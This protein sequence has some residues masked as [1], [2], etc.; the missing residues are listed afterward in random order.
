MTIPPEHDTDR[1]PPAA[2]ASVATREASRG[3]DV[4]CEPSDLQA[5]T[6]MHGWIRDLFPICR[7]LTGPG[8]RQTLNY[9]GDL[10]PGLQVSSIPSGTKVFDWTV[11][12][13]WTLRAARLVGPDGRVVAD[14]AAHTLHVMGYSTPVDEDF[15]L[16]QLQPHLY[17]LPAQP[18]AIPYVTSYYRRDWGFCIPHRVRQ[19]LPAGT[20]RAMIDSTLADGVL[21]W[22]ELVIRG[23]VDDEVLLSTYICHPSMANNELSG[24]VLA[25]ALAR[26]L[27]SRD[28]RRLTHRIVFVPETI[29][30][31][32][33]L[34]RH[35]DHLRARTVAGF[36]LTCVGDERAVSYLESP[37]ADTLADRTARH[38]L[39][40]AA[41]GYRTYRFL[42]RGSDERQYCSPGVRLP[43]CSVM[44]SKHG[45]FPEYHTSLDDLAFVTPKGLAGSFALYRRMLESLES[46]GTFDCPVPC[47]PQLGRRGLYP[48]TSWKD[49]AALPRLQS[50]IL[51]YSDGG[52]DLLE[53]AEIVGAD[54]R[55]C[56]VIVDRLVAHGLLREVARHGED[57]RGNR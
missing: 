39:K 10:L 4:V 17:S 56:R 47:E 33:Y 24:P 15:T 31:I 46:N 27:L 40:H 23:D 53:I 18:D 16:E 36:V 57:P 12:P 35:I 34:S 14:A 29:G 13:E 25:T 37:F 54:V 21:N 5:G 20:Y 45:T 2:N 51:S 42:D 8:V 22:G 50:D 43:V 28:R 55:H 44:R 11:P 9:L 52:R 7:S 38:V 26:W 6:E 30:S 3:P 32:A 1:Q 41:P 49:G 19:S 48:D